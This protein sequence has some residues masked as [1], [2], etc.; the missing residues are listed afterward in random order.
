[1][2]HIAVVSTNQYKYSETFIHRHVEMLPAKVH[3][4][5]DG[6]L[7]HHYT[8]KG[9]TGRAQPFGAN[10]LLRRLQL[11]PPKERLQL[12]IQQYLLQHKIKAVLAEYGPSGVEMLPVCEAANIPLIVHFHGYDAYRQDMMQTYGGQYPALFNRADAV[13]AVS[14]HMCQRLQ[15]LGCPPHKIHHTACGADTDLF[16]TRCQPENNPPLFV[17]VGRF[18]DTKAP[19]LTI[20]AFA[21]ALKLA[22]EAKLVMAGNGHLLEACQ[23]LAKALQITH[24]VTFLGS[25]SHTQVMQLMQGARA[26][27]QHSVTTPQNDTE[28]T[29]VSVMEA[30]ASGLPVIATTHA[31][32][33]DVVI[34][35]HTGF[36]V[37]EGNITGMAAY[38][39]RLANE[40]GLA[41][42]LGA[43]AAKHIGQHFTLQQHIDTLWEIVSGCIKK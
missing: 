9:V 18:A 19:H 40:P 32:I 16:N 14:K 11:K 36:L 7:P 4:F 12:A 39:E 31:G 35:R 21:Q 28:G 42:A 33:P 41:G 20:L 1:M 22:P 13:V 17:S 2:H 34:H 15:D 25:I 27:V 38:M 30:G 43:A 24:A 10:S 8:T 23:I 5:F 37:S 6:Y 29:P 3:Y 26:F